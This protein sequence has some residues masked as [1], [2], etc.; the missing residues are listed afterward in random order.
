[1]PYIVPSYWHW[2]PTTAEVSELVSCTTSTQNS[3]KVIS[4][5][6]LDKTDA[7]RLNTGMVQTTKKVAMKTGGGNSYISKSFTIVTIS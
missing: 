7:L 6:F 4:V 2:K 1:M 5:P 3:S